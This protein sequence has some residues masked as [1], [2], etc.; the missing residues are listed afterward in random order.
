[1]IHADPDNG[2]TTRPIDL[3]MEADPRTHGSGTGWTGRSLIP[4]SDAELVRALAT[5]LRSALAERDKLRRLVDGI[6]E[7]VTGPA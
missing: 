5:E 7:M 2:T 3:I 4:L 6:E 1:M